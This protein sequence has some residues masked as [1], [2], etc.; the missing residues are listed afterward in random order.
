MS[1]AILIVSQYDAATARGAAS[2]S[3]FPWLLERNISTIS[4]CNDLR[5][6]QVPA[7]ESRPETARPKK[8][9]QDELPRHIVD[10]WLHS[11]PSTFGRWICHNGLRGIVRH[12]LFLRVRI[13]SVEANCITGHSAS[14]A[15][16]WKTS[17]CTNVLFPYYA[18]LT[19]RGSSAVECSFATRFE[20]WAFSFSPL[21]P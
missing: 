8:S 2:K 20:D 21:M 6:I 3:A 19:E 18:H 9:E 15:S 4:C 16:T 5:M 11:F 12:Y 14:C 1:S 17:P 10:G 7:Y 13:A